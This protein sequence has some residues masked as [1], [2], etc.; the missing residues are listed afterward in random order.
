MPLNRKRLLRSLLAGLAVGAIGVTCYMLAAWE[1]TRF[2]YLPWSLA[3][4]FVILLASG[5]IAV[6]YY[7]D[8]KPE[9]NG[10]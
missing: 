6:M 8:G 5:F 3:A 10:D 4:G 1:E 2:L 9:G 7:V